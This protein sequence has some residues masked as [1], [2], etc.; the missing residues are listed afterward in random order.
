MNKKRSRS[1]KEDDS[2]TLEDVLSLIDQRSNPFINSDDEK[3]EYRDNTPRIPAPLKQSPATI[4]SDF[5][6]IAVSNTHLNLIDSEEPELS[7][8]SNKKCLTIVN[9]FHLKIDF[10]KSQID[11]QYRRHQYLQEYNHILK[12]LNNIFVLS[13][14]AKTSQLDFRID[15]F[16]K[17]SQAI[18][19][20]FLLSDQPLLYFTFSVLT[21]PWLLILKESSLGFNRLF[22]QLHNQIP[23]ATVIGPMNSPSELNQFVFPPNNITNE[24]EKEKAILLKEVLNTYQINDKERTYFWIRYDFRSVRSSINEVDPNHTEALTIHTNVRK[25]VQDRISDKNELEKS[26]KEKQKNLPE[27]PKDTQ[28]EPNKQPFFRNYGSNPV[29]KQTAKENI[30]PTK[31][32]D[33]VA[34]IN[35]ESSGMEVD[36]DFSPSSLTSNNININTDDNNNNNMDISVPSERTN[37]EISENQILE[38]YSKG[39]MMFMVVFMSYAKQCDFIL[40]S[41]VISNN[42]NNPSLDLHQRMNHIIKNE[43]N[44]RLSCIRWVISTY[45]NDPTLNPA[46][47]VFEDLNFIKEIPENNLSQLLIIK[48]FDNS[49]NLINGYAQVTQFIIHFLTAFIL[50]RIKMVVYNLI[51]EDPHPEHYQTQIFYGELA[52]KAF[53]EFLSHIVSFSQNSSSMIDSFFNYEKEV[54]EL[55]TSITRE[56]NTN[57]SLQSWFDILNMTIIGKGSFEN[58]EKRIQT[59]MSVRKGFGDFVPFTMDHLNSA[60][61]EELFIV[62]FGGKRSDVLNTHSKHLEVAEICKNY[63]ICSFLLL[64]QKE[65]EKMK[66]LVQIIRLLVCGAIETENKIKTIITHL[67]KKSSKKI[68]K[69]EFWDFMYAPKNS[70]DSNESWLEDICSNFVD[71]SITVISNFISQHNH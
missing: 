37:E 25:I 62:Y 70:K 11:R 16:I 69:S 2:P 20:E 22:L 35:S 34:I 23:H 45:H 44:E 46:F 43:K 71:H 39:L 38:F 60:R 58:M 31:T 49:S 1:S 57:L 59:K 53:F 51:K 42:S 56:E 66:N 48:S 10:N 29:G 52:S 21:K 61:K 64:N 9:L 4:S 50:S 41:S 18:A 55:I 28:P 5:I 17:D 68:S 33:T 15:S 63:P 36:S 67:Q 54:I 13:M 26:L 32:S 65:L 12:W 24:E 8:L 6:E 27:I 47:L 3:D 40:E 14:P 7:C 19:F 30:I